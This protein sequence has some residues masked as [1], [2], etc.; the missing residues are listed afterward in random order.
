MNAAP[1]SLTQMEV[2]KRLG[3]SRARI[4]QIEKQALEKMREKLQ[5]DP[6]LFEAFRTVV[7]GPRRS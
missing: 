4:C 7:A 1:Q 3:L 5:H 6:E 2:A